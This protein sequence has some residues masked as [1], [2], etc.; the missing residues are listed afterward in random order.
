MDTNLESKISHLVEILC[1]LKYF[2]VLCIV[3]LETL[4]ISYQDNYQNKVEFRQLQLKWQKIYDQYFSDEG[5]RKV[6]FVGFLT[7]VN[8]VGHRS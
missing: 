5:N 7:N 8:I 3:D 1:N 4:L 2:D 6:E